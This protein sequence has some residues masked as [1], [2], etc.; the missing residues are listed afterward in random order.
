MNKKSEDQKQ[1]RQV[2]NKIGVLFIDYKNDSMQS[3][4]TYSQFIGTLILFEI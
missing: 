4:M 2:S 1:A 3:S